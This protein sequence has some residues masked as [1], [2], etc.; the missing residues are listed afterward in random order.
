[1]N[2]KAIVR[3]KGEKEE[4]KIPAILY[5]RKIKENPVLW[6]E[7]N[8]F[9][10]LYEQA[11]EST[12]VD[13]DLGGKSHKVLIHDVQFDPLKG[14]V[15]HVDFYQ[16]VMDEEVE[17]EIEFEFVGEALAVKEQGGI[18]VK[19]LDAITVRCLPGDLPKEI[20]VDISTLKT[21]EDNIRVKDLTIG[22]KEKVKFSIDEET[23]VASVSRPRTEE[24]LE[25]L[26]K[27]V[28]TDISQ[29][30]GMKKEGEEESAAASG[31]DE[32]P[33]SAKGSDEVKK[34]DKK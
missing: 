33:A 21:F 8:E 20:K 4:A 24:E 6:V 28:E 27:E 16:V 10:K 32:K 5:G 31:G 1:M 3:K 15:R 19:S 12:L 17:A 29:V 25:D 26:N 9:N 18:L 14:F 23:M 7:R 30:E 34:D 2:I 22:D 11:G 13:L